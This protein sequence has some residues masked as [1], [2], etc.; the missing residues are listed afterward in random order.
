MMLKLLIFLVLTELV[1]ENGLLHAAENDTTSS[2]RPKEV[3]IGAIFAFDTTIG[4]VAK[5]AIQ[6]ALDD[7]NDS[8]SVLHGTKLN[9]TMKDSI[10]NGLVGIVEAMSFLTDNVVA[11]IG[12]QSSVTAHVLAYLAKGLKVPLLSF[13]ASDPTLSSLEYPF[14]VRTTQNDFFQMAAIANIVDYFG[15]RKVTAIYNDDDFGRNGIAVLEDL[16]AKT[17]CTISYKAAMN[18]EPSEEDIKDL[19]YQVSLQESRILVLHT[20]TTNGPKV[21]EVA[22]SLHM[23]SSGYVWIA[24]DWLTDIIDTDSPLSP[25]SLSDVQGLLTLRSHTPQSEAKKKFVARWSNLTRRENEND[26]FRLNTYG[27]YAYDTVWI[28]AHALNEYFSQG[29]NI[30]FS[31]SSMLSQLSESNLRLDSMKVFDGGEV[32]LSNVRRVKMTGLTGNIQYDSDRN[33]INP[34]YDIVNVVGTGHITVGYWTNSSGLSVNPPEAPSSRPSNLTNPRQQ[35]YSVI[36]PG[37]TTDTPRGWVFPSNGHHLTIGVPYR[38]DYGAIISYSAR[39]NSFTGYAIDVFTSAVNLLPYALPYKLVPFG[40]GIHNPNLDELIDKMSGGV[41]DAVVGDIPITTYRLTKADFTL[42]YIESGLVVVAPVNAKDSNAWAFLKP[43][44]PVM[45]FTILA[46]LIFVGSVIWI[47]E[48]RH[49]D[50]FRGPPREQ[51]VTM[52]WF[53]LS[54]WFFSHRESTV[55]A[56]GRFVL[57]MWLFV[58]LII[59]SSYTASLTSILTVQE[60][61]SNVKGI[62][63][64]VASNDR[65][66]YREGSYIYSYLHK[67]L[68][69]PDSRLVALNSENESAEAL[70]K[71]SGNGGISA[72]VDIKA[73]MEIFLSTRCEFSTV[74]QEFTRNGWGFAF[75]R[76]SQLATDLSTAILRLSE[77]GDLQRIHDKW[78][79][80]S[81]CSSQDTRLSVD[82][83]QLQSFW[84]LY[85]IMGLACMSALL[86]Y[87]GRAVMQFIRHYTPK[88]EES[89]VQNVTASRSPQLQRVQ[90]FL[91]FIDEKEEDI[92]RRSL[93]RQLERSSTASG[94]P[95]LA[96]TLSFP[97]SSMSDS[98]ISNVEFSPA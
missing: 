29:G 84:G 6:A 37:Q 7:V 41:F 34:A 28:L 11:I 93:R 75:P 31:N 63:S 17:Q 15:W 72:I 4:K 19:L 96:S 77:N 54:T 45:W 16:L 1:V 82:V 24:T 66:G 52:L 36:W 25:T 39:T 90:T 79:Q 61:T 69:V 18:P 73:Y 91:S 40:N 22:R 81:A 42:P 5:V 70:R 51:I 13:A 62:Q 47:L 2:T 88:E 74:G 27:L 94:T 59:N 58:V 98:R 64:L 21:L 71:G 53:S 55:S 10:F 23:L 12:P 65:I 56:L 14:F 68:G 20:Y 57:I 78:L 85:L 95:R 32:L 80:K 83:L 38:V 35:L 86:V 44:T 46:S 26:L 30:S 33:L 97:N 8:P 43:F 3:N 67:E 9:I 50:D 48:H 87:F 92:K 76:G 60:L 49:N 89:N